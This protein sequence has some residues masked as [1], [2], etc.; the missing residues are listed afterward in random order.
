VRLI[1]LKKKSRVEKIG[2]LGVRL[3]ATLATLTCANVPE[4]DPLIAISPIISGKNYISQ[5]LRSN[6]TTQIAF[7]REVV[8]DR[9]TLIGDLMAG[10]AVNVDGYLLTKGLYQEIEAINL[11]DQQLSSFQRVLLLQ[12]SKRKN[13]P[14]EKRLEELYEK[15]KGTI[16]KIELLNMTADY[17]WADNKVYN[18]QATNIQDA[19]IRWLRSNQLVGG[20]QIES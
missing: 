19:I 2:L 1:S 9:E 18:A 17:F 7:Y 4:I 6:L 5:C 20:C 11:S 14:I 8:K 3:G 13:Q 10:N 12:V 16:N 15:Y